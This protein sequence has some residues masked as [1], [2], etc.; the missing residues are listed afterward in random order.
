MNYKIFIFLEKFVAFKT[1]WLR[2][3]F[4][5]ELTTFFAIDFLDERNKA[6]RFLC[7]FD[8]FVIFWILVDFNARFDFWLIHVNV[9]EWFINLY[10]WY[11]ENNSSKFF[12]F[13]LLIMKL[14]CLTNYYIMSCL[15]FKISSFCN[16]FNLDVFLVRI[17]FYFEINWIFFH[18]FCFRS[19]CW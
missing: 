16:L 15:N 1:L 7:D 13:L 19:C 18:F 2:C 8:E 9:V 10:C 4:V 17:F 11:F 6:M 5:L 12:S 3:K 14:I